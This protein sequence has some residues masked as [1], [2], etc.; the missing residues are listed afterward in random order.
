MAQTKEGAYLLAEQGVMTCLLSLSRSL[1]L[2]PV[3]GRSPQSLWGL[4]GPF[5]SRSLTPR[6]PPPK[7]F[8]FAVGRLVKVAYMA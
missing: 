7:D 3:H 6:S 8:S 2:P 1:L 4:Q 5:P